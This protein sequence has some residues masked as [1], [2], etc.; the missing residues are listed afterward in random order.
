MIELVSDRIQ[1]IVIPICCLVQTS[2]LRF[3]RGF[4]FCPQFTTAAAIQPVENSDS[5]IGLVAV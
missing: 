2:I 3:L 1:S 5:Q 4:G